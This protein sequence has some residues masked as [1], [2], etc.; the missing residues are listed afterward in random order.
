ML[1]ISASFKLILIDAFL[2]LFKTCLSID[3]FK[4]K[5]VKT[6]PDVKLL[7]TP[8]CHISTL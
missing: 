2:I 5:L 1:I 3:L 8:T 4:L 6:G 7:A